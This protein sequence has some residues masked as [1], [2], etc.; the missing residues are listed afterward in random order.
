MAVWL[1]IALIQIVQ[2]GIDNT[3]IDHGIDN[4]SGECVGGR[5]SLCGVGA[6]CLQNVD[7]SRTICRKAHRS[8]CESTRSFI[9]TIATE[10]DLTLR[11]Y[12][13]Y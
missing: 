5:I 7:R 6:Q 11:G 9:Y 12:S 13:V 1:A 4:H 8:R 10:T 3:L 2:H